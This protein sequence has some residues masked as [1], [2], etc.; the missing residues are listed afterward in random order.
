MTQILYVVS[1]LE[2][3]L[4][5]RL[6][7]ALEAKKDGFHISVAAPNAEGNPQLKQ[8]GIEGH[9]IPSPDQKLSG[10]SAFKLVRRLDDIMRD[11]QPDIVHAITLKYAFLTGLAARRNKR[12]QP[13]YT[14]AGL[15]YL[16][17]SD[18]I[19]PKIMRTLLRP[20]IRNVFRNAQI[21]VQNPDDEQILVRQ[22]F[23]A[24]EQSNLVR[25]SGVD[26]KRFSPANSDQNVPIVLMPTRLIH[27]KGIAVFIEA[28]NIL[29][30]RGID[31]HFQIAGGVTSHNPLAISQ[32]EM[33]C[34]V[35]GTNTEWIGKV[36]DM[37]ALYASSTIIV[38]PSYYGEG[39]P[40]VLIEAAAC[41]KAIVTTD[42]IGCRE[43]VK[44]GDNGFLVPVK[45]ATATADAIEKLLKDRNLRA[46]ME[47]R[48]RARAESEFDINKIAR[49]TADIYKKI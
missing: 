28:A 1:E 24:Q 8:H 2:D 7:V 43:A 44:D 37:P 31:A 27:D 22:R 17:S 14:I 26:L 9:N 49:Q 39:I 45:N 40:R 34:M 15:G 20:I 4:S 6:P 47:K 35:Q 5:S 32:S 16:F 46:Q 13:V 21:I 12:I 33:E 30:Q 23:I 11:T 25:G 29:K 19:K 36:V 41:G 3:F 48:G 42:H 18:S 10:A 38:Y